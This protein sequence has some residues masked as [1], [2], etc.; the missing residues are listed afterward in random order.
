MTLFTWLCEIGGPRIARTSAALVICITGRYIAVSV[1]LNT[2]HAVVQSAK[3]SNCP[4]DI[5]LTFFSPSANLRGREKGGPVCCREEGA[6]ALRLCKLRTRYRP[7]RTAL[8]S[9]GRSGCTAGIRSAG[10]FD[11]EQRSCRH[12]GRTHQCPLAWT[13][14]VGCRADNASQYRPQGDRRLRGRTTPDQ[15]A[16]TEGM[17]PRTN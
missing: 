3:P 1:E 16:A 15:D 8:R 7:A 10:L 14:R 9:R 5:L 4:L 17:S 2:S 13:E 6:F 11:S 12:Q